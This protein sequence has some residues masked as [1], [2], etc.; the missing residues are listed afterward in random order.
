MAKLEKKQLE[1]A[2]KK[3]TKDARKRVAVRGVLQ[4]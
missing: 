3:L 1:R 4:F 2:H